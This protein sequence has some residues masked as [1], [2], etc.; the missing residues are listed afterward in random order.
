MANDLIDLRLELKENLKNQIQNDF[1][2]KV[3]VNSISFDNPISF[4]DQK[5]VESFAAAVLMVQSCAV[6]VKTNAA[7]KE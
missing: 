7:S 5:I 4:N 3:D 6:P 2:S 1:M